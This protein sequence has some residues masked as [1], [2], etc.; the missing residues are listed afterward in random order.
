MII[1]E[2]RE[3]VDGIKLVLY[4]RNPTEEDHQYEM[5]CRN[6]S[7][8]FLEI[9]RQFKNG[10]G[11]YVYP[12]GKYKALKSLYENRE[13]SYEVLRRLM[14][15]IK[16]A[17]EKA[18]ELLLDENG[19]LL[20]EDFIFFDEEGEHF[21]FVY[22]SPM[23]GV[24]DYREGF[25]RLS[26]FIV[27]H[28]DSA[29][30]A[31]MDLAYSIFKEARSVRFTIHNVL[32]KIESRD[33]QEIR[34]AKARRILCAELEPEEDIKEEFSTKT[35]NAKGYLAVVAFSILA[36][37]LLVG[38]LYVNKN[39]IPTWSDYLLGL[40]FLGVPVSILIRQSSV[41]SDPTTREW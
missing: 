7:V 26:D 34:D 19:V 3:E 10:I 31:G 24:E 23:I 1:S 8:E 21:R 29:D 5:L 13:I 41:N 25:R 27:E 32:A 37:V 33:E 40:L 35:M 18:S 15:A 22:Y 2:Y 9:Q 36:F 20:D 39:G 16:A 12:I 11:S 38:N 30:E 4:D 14:V 17:I 6:P 28:M